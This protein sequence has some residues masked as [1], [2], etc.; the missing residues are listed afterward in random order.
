MPVDV[1]II[2]N[3]TF[4]F[5]GAALFL[6]MMMGL[7]FI[8]V[9]WLNNALHE[10]SCT[11]IAQEVMLAAI[12]LMYF[13]RARHSA[14]QRPVMVLVAGFFSCM[15]IRE[16]DFLFDEIFHGSWSWFALATALACLAI[17]LREPHRILPGLAAM[18]SHSSWSLMSAGM[19]TTLVFSRLFGMHELWEHLM[20]DGYNR[21]VKNI[22]EEGSELLGYSLCLFATF[23]YV[24]QGKR[25]VSSQKNVSGSAN[26]LAGTA[27]AQ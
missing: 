5:L 23:S 17:A 22:A 26:R 4:A 6:S 24:W 20:L 2:K 12:A 13:N 11:E 8:D 1:T 25:Q 10:T 7:V 15:L 18:M 16:L 9:V 3:K 14:A 27:A 19:L 21:T